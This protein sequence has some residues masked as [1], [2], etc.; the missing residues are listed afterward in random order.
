ME[1]PGNEKVKKMSDNPDETAYYLRL[2]A[3]YID[4]GT[5]TVLKVFYTLTPKK[6]VKTFFDRQDIKRILTSLDEKKIISVK[7]FRMVSIKPNP[8]NFDMSLLITLLTNLYK[9][10]L[11]NPQNGWKASPDVRDVSIA[12]DLLRLRNI[13]NTIVG[14]YPRARLPKVKFEYIWNHVETVLIRLVQNVDATSATGLKE[15]IS[16]YKQM[17]LDPNTGSA[18]MYQE[19]LK[20]WW[21]NCEE[22]S[23]LQ[24]K[25]ED[26]V[27]KT[28]EFLLFF[29]E[30]PKRY[31]RY[32]R[33]LFEG[34]RLVLT[35]VIEHEASKCRQPL[36]TILLDKQDVI[37]KEMEN[38]QMLQICPNTEKNTA[39][40]INFD[41]WDIAVL[42]RV[43][44]NIFS[45]SIDGLTKENV[46]TLVD[47]RNS[48]AN[49]AL[50]SL[51]SE[52]FTSYCED[53]LS[54]IRVLSSKLD[55]EAYKRCRQ[56]IAEYK[57][58]T[59]SQVG[60]IE[61][62]LVQLK[63]HGVQVKTIAE[64]YQD[65]LETL[66]DAVTKMEVD[67]V[68]FMQEHRI[69]LKIITLGDDKEKKETAEKTL[70]T[71]W[72]A[73]I[74]LSDDPTDFKA[75]RKA[76]D[77]ILDAVREIVDAHVE[78]ILQGCILVKLRCS[79]GR[80][81]QQVIVYFL[82]KE[83]QQL[84]EIISNE[85][86]FIYDDV[87]VM[88]GNFTIESLLEILNNLTSVPEKAQPYLSLPIQCTSA[89]G[90]RKVLAL[91]GEEKTVNR[92][93]E[94]AESLS[95]Q[96]GD[97]IMLNISS[98]VKGFCEVF[99]RKVD[100]IANLRNEIDSS[101]TQPR[102]R[103][104][105]E[106]G[107]HQYLK[108]TDILETVSSATE[109]YDIDGTTETYLK[110]EIDSSKAQS[111]TSTV[112]EEGDYQFQND[113]D[114][115]TI[116]SSATELSNM[117]VASTTERD[118]Y[119]AQGLSLQQHRTEGHHVGF[120]LGSK[121]YYEDTWTLAS[122]ETVTIMSTLKLQ[123]EKRWQCVVI[124]LKRTTDALHPYIKSRL[125]SE[126]ERWSLNAAD[127]V[128]QFSKKVNNDR[129]YVVYTRSETGRGVWKI[130]DNNSTHQD[131]LGKILSIHSNPAIGN[132]HFDS[133]DS[134]ICKDVEPHWILAKIFMPYGNR[135]S[136][137]PE[138]SDVLSFFDLLRNCR[139]LSKDFDAEALDELCTA[140]F[141]ITSKTSLTKLE[142]DELTAWMKVLLKAPCLKCQPDVTHLIQELNDL[143]GTSVSIT[144]PD[145]KRLK[146]VMDD[147]FPG[148]SFS[149]IQLT[150]GANQ[151]FNRFLN[152]GM[153]NLEEEIQSENAKMDEQERRITTYKRMG[154]VA[155]ASI[156]GGSGIAV[157]GAAAALFG[158]PVLLPAVAVGSAAAGVGYV[159]GRAGG[160]VI[161]M[162]KKI[163]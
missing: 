125:T 39:L 40:D 7:E 95:D 11:P 113:T 82:S 49:I 71:V 132:I 108:D 141:I 45:D 102:T 34:G 116:A 130:R 159:G 119:L 72:Q 28:N 135:T 70:L 84:L 146:Q 2:I 62:Y 120:D 24:E 163:L 59:E 35:G 60:D 152:G 79:S 46:Q 36:R 20:E 91:F 5:D 69:E 33:L 137:N 156:V 106:E 143:E 83:F 149:S 30:K 51:D 128:R 105:S 80:A 44:I 1:L 86:S 76:V 111:R 37:R 142:M 158:A 118:S 92:F 162:F 151:L 25:V 138:E 53:L 9:G 88:R 89:E 73:A 97:R 22:I 74:K 150:E 12:A 90:M 21:E 114:I 124:Y 148:T 47:A 107:N 54:S 93:N 145:I 81:L 122:K 104:V 32:I 78:S 127:D 109:P 75:L 139:S 101:K 61:E 14:H 155:G 157:A 29:K 56:I 96:L 115:P 57:M 48:Y 63:S 160:A 10:K 55:E 144:S 41:K 121:E 98:D 87:M 58:E 31:C 65:T 67:G 16:E 6:D 110:N 52:R 8:E 38:A 77:M 134:M 117:A 23:K 133:N 26:L 161:A 140:R 19:K 13:R 17:P 64:V 43:I 50:V 131:I 66:K 68:S 3:M 147:Y 112:F 18:L 123:D 100:M 103:T 15:T 85:L 42:G 136:R 129:S 94:I 126:L 4:I 153:R 27:K 99:D 154:G